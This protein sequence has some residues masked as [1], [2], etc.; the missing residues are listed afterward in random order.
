M[1]RTDRLLEKK[2]DLLEIIKDGTV[3]QIAFQDTNQPYIV[4]L[5]YGYDWSNEALLF[6]FHSARE[7][8]KI[9]LIKTSPRVCFS[10]SICDPFI[11]GE[12]ACNY[13]MKYRSIV[14]Y[15]TI[16]ILENEQERKNGLNLLMMKYTGKSQWHYDEE[17]LNKTT[18][19]CL[20]VEKLSGKR[21][22]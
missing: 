19:T 18:V 14:G 15:G 3:M 5:N 22:E 20:E 2:D 1:R 13:G 12:K 21:K 17:M 7:G 6:Y 4:T 16:R 10:I 11:A 9:D 8:R